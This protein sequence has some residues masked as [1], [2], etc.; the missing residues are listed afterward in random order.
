MV[1]RAHHPER[2]SKLSLVE[3][4]ITMTKIQNMRAFRSLVLEIWVL[5]VIWC[6][7]FG[8]YLADAK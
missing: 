4:L 3:G 7:E 2:L 1:R 5:F 8:I 6:L